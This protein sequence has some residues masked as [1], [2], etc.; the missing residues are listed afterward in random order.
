M[1]DA[2]MLDTLLVSALVTGLLLVLP[3]WR[4][5]TRAGLAPAWSLVA[6][7]PGFGPLLALL[8]LGLRAWPVLRAGSR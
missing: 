4:I 2:A 6:F 5:F 7:V 3:L 1:Q 8:L